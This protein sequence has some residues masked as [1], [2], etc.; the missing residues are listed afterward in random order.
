M[1]KLIFL[2]L[3]GFI[4]GCYT[5]A[6]FNSSIK[7]VG[8]ETDKD[9]YH[10][11]EVMHISAYIDSPAAFKDVKVRFY[12]I[13]SGRYRLDTTKIVDFV[14]G[15]NTVS[16]DYNAPRCYGCAGIKPGT[17]QINVDVIYGNQ[18]LGTSS[19]DIEI[20]Q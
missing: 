17:Y 15:K 2:I 11:G 6:K 9:L 12:G 4:A 18:T 13:Y 1:K 16:I 10:S 14:S 5:E 3:I 19:V 7:E 8:L 20:R